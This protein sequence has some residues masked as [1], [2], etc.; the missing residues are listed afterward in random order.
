MHSEILTIAVPCWMGGSAGRIRI[1]NVR[2]VY[3]TCNRFGLVLSQIKRFW[4]GLVANQKILIRESWIRACSES[5]SMIRDS[6]LVAIFLEKQR[7]KVDSNLFLKWFDSRLI[8][9]STMNRES[10]IH[11]F[12]FNK[13]SRI[14]YDLNQDSNQFLNWF[15]THE[16]EFF[17]SRQALLWINLKI[18]TSINK[19]Q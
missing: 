7:E 1:T 17:D 11:N 2:G 13:D 4:L 12:L 8:R 6:N 19:H 3:Y 18:V 14:I 5:E 15:T 16:S 10:K 9:E